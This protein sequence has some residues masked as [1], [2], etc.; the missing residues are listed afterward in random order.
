M[1]DYEG[2]CVISICPLI[3]CY[4]SVSRHLA[5]HLAARILGM[6]V[7]A[8][9]DKFQKFQRTNNLS[10]FTKFSLRNYNFAH[11]THVCEEINYYLNCHQNLSTSLTI[12]DSNVSIMLVYLFADLLI[13]IV[14]KNIRTPARGIDHVNN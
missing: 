7:A 9:G 8:G 1:A 2:K 10:E 12:V 13:M 5:C 11:Y 4:V 14:C 3:V 6:R